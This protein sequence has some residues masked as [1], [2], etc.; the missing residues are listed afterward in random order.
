I[1][2]VIENAEIKQNLYRKV[3]QARKAG[4]A[5]SSNTSTIPLSR[6]TRDMPKR[7]R[8]D[9]LIT[10]FF[11]PPRYMRLLEL[12]A[13][14]RTRPEI[15]QGLR[16]F[17]DI[18]LGKGVVDCKDTPGF[19]GNRI[20]IFW[21]QCAV[22]AAVSN[23]IT[24]EQAD[25]V[26]SAPVG[27]PKTGV[28]GLLDLVGLDLMPHIIDSMKRSLPADD[29]F[30]AIAEVPEIIRKLLAQGYTGRKGKGG[31]Y[32]LNPDAPSK[33]KESADLSTGLFRPSEKPKLDSVAAC[34][35]GGLR[36]L[37][38]FD[39]DTGRYALRVLAKTLSYAAG[40]VPEIA[41]DIVAVDQAMKLGYNW[42]Y[43][44]FEL[45]DRMGAAWFVTKL[46]SE[47]MT[48]PA[49]LQSVE[50]LYR[51][52][53]GR[54]LHIGVDKQYRPV[55]RATGVLLLSDVKLRTEPLKRNMSASLWDIGD[56]VLC[57]EFH[58]KMNTLDGEMLEL[59]GQAIA[60][61]SANYKAL[62]I[63]N[64]ADNFSAGANLGILMSAI[65]TAAWAE[66][67]NLLR[68]GQNTYKALKY[69]PFPVVA[70]PSGLALGGGCEILLHCDAIQAHAELYAG[71]VEVGV[72]LIPGWGGCKE[73]LHRWQNAPRFPG[74]PMPAIAKAFGI[75]AKA[76]VSKSAAEAKKRLFLD[77]KIGITMNKDRL[78]ADAK[79]KALALSTNYSAPEPPEF[80]LPG[81]SGKAALM[82]AIQTV[83]S[84]GKATEYD[85]VVST[86]LAEVLTGGDSDLTTPLGED[87]LLK[88]E[89]QAFLKLVK[90]KRTLARLQHM[91]ETG[92]PLRN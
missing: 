76:Q 86:R 54:L 45:I 75:I 53:G 59:T 43:G 48:V 69:A 8:R 49:L 55:K 3:D 50:R 9:F 15:L 17:A 51:V 11:N 20:G 52:D 5:M 61:V 60:I 90:E 44:P 89:R 68:Q 38:E 57:L 39:D 83:R 78:L 24:V 14:D 47:G 56:G 65:N 25:T 80:R 46:R 7:F 91:L 21:L 19:I 63:H 77:A 23:G 81:P 28:F 6:L 37:L 36:A 31:F 13:G 92:K 79:A 73:L 87:D 41:D 72:G 12:V 30:H 40:L 58:S 29:D 33:V 1:E 62:V 32:R 67:D 85:E 64:E 84:K 27:I 42:K 35:T 34:K 16:T 18:K 82:M 2:A 10:H 88:L 66:V 4:S 74:G 71:L 22:T 70:A 26:M